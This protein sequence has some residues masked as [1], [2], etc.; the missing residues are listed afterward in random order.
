MRY[1]RHVLWVSTEP[2]SRLTPHAPREL[3]VETEALSP[4][5]RQHGHT[6][7]CGLHGES[8]PLENVVP[9]GREEPVH[10]RCYRGAHAGPE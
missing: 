7:E 3:H 5:A 10:S 6:A 4:D 1:S 2:P 8:G 9:D